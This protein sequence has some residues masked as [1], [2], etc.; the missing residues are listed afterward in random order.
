MN[1]D[2][3]LLSDCPSPR[4]IGSYCLFHGAREEAFGDP[5]AA[6]RFYRQDRFR[7]LGSIAEDAESG[8]W[9]WLGVPDAEGY[10]HV[11]YLGRYRAAHRAIWMLLIGPLDDH[12]TLD[13]LCHNRDSDCPGGPRCP[14]RRC[15]NPDHLE[16]VPIGV[17]A[18][19]SALTI[20]ARH[21]AATACPQGHPYTIEN[22][23]MVNGGR[24]RRCRICRNEQARLSKA[25]S[26]RSRHEGAGAA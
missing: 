22:T 8:C 23:A 12:L 9:R 7:L 18:R 3:C 5:L 26:R 19:R 15:V 17:N 24:S 10:G 11:R 20:A 21:A 16:P 13:H 6:R 14:H 2:T 4:R 1:N 25:K